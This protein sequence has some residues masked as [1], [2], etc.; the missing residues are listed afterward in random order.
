MSKYL[1]FFSF[2]LWR[3]GGGGNGKPEAL[4]EENKRGEGGLEMFLRRENEKNLRYF[5]TVP[6]WWLFFK[7]FTVYFIVCNK[8]QYKKNIQ[9]L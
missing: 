3:K 2:S 8:L 9:I 7:S 4:L 6:N 5:H 1:K